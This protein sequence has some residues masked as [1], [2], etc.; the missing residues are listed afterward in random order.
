MRDSFSVYLHLPYCAKRCP[1]CDFTTYVVHRIPEDRYV[2]T[3]LREVA[4]SATLAEWSG[5]R[6]AT[7]FFGGGTPSLF[8]PGSIGRLLRAIDD[9]W[10]IEAG[11]EITMEANPGTLEG[12]AEARLADFRAAGLT[13]LSFGV[14]SFDP[15]HLATLGRIH[16]GD[17][18][19]AAIGAAHRAGFDN[20]SCDLI[21]G[22]PGQTLDEWKDDVARAIELGTEHVSAYGLTYEEG[23][24]MTG[25]KKAG[26]IT[27]ADEDT[28]LAMFRHAREAFAAAGLAQYEISNYSRPG[29][30]SRHNLAYWTWGDYLGLGAGAHGFAASGRRGDG[31]SGSEQ[32][33]GDTACVATDQTPNDER[34]ASQVVA[35]ARS[36][37]RATASGEQSWG[38][39]YANIRLPELYMSAGPGRWHASEESLTREMAMAE[40]LMVRLRLARGIDT[41]EFEHR[42]GATIDAAA[43]SLEGFVQAGLLARRNGAIVLTPRG[44]ELADDVITRLAAA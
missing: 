12:S 20:V 5:R 34:A 29:R 33:A 9:A 26:M 7:V 3:L 23:T 11:A 38:R 25:L 15:K 41:A 8:S 13:R 28:E 44:L 22:V 42:F 10:G 35:E 30:E 31:T 39:R 4:H 24:P 19:V 17:E 2:E 18:A 43:P 40:Y 36:D 16:S 32:A 27:A 6:V 21:F 1:Y 14:Q 37:E